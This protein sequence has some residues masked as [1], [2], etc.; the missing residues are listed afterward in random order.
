[1][2]WTRYAFFIVLTL[3]LGISFIGK[4]SSDPYPLWDC[5]FFPAYAVWIFS[6]DGIHLDPR[7]LASKIDCGE[8]G[9]EVTY[10]FRR[11]P[12]RLRWENIWGM[13]FTSSTC[14]IHSD[15]KLIRFSINENAGFK[16]KK[17]IL[18]T[19]VRRAALRFVEGRFWVPYYRRSD[20][21]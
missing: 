1:M 21:P 8:A 11:Q 19:I 13:D 14:V 18:K 6:L 4:F 10:R 5:I 2:I 20:A 15:S 12:V 3:V 17:V 16:T 7:R 9:L